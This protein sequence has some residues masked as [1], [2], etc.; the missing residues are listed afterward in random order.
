MERREILRPRHDHKPVDALVGE[1]GHV[2]LGKLAGFRF[3]AALVGGSSRGRGRA[4]GGVHLAGTGVLGSR[5]LAA[6]LI[7][8]IRG[9]ADKIVDHIRHFFRV[10]IL[11]TDDLDFHIGRG[12][13]IKLLDDLVEE[14]HVRLGGHHDEFVRPL[15]GDNK[16]FSAD[17]AAVGVG[18]GGDDRLDALGRLGLLVAVAAQQTVGAY[19]RTAH[20]LIGG[21]VLHALA[22][23]LLLLHGLFDDLLQMSLHILRGGMDD[24][25]DKDILHHRR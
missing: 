14:I 24:L 11:K 7:L 4:G 20:R 5:V 12:L 17:H 22:V 8:R 10:G 13:D 6:F 23:L 16:H 18:N 21:I 25:T 15:V 9:V 3:P 2:V 19:E 1:N